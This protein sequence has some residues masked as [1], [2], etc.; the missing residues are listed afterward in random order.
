MRPFHYWAIA[1]AAFGTACSPTS[2]T[3]KTVVTAAKDPRVGFN[4][5]PTPAEPH[6][7][8]KPFEYMEA[9]DKL[10]NYVPSD[11]WGVQGDAITTMQKPLS[12]EESQKHYVLP[13]GFEAKLF[14][15]E[16]DIYKPI[17]LAW[18]ARGR[19]WISE[20]RD[21]PNEIQPEGQGRDQ[22]KICED[23]DGDGKADK[24]TVFADKLSIA[25]TFAFANGGIV[26]MQA[27]EALF[28]KD[29]DGDDKAD[30]RKVLFTGWSMNDTHATVSNLRMGPDG[31]LWG[32]VGY[33]GFRGTVGGQEHRFGQGFFRCKPDGSA[34]EFVR[35]SNNNTWGL[36]FD[37]NGVVFGSTANGNAYMYMPIANH[38]YEAVNGWSVSRVDSIATS[39]NF[40]PITKQVRQVDWH[41]KYTAGAGAALYTARSFPMEYWN[42]VGF[43]CEPTGH[44]IGQF[45][46]EAKGA[47]FVAHNLKTF[48]GSD[49]EW[50]SPI[51]AEVGPDGALWVTD[52]YNYII[53]H[54]P[55]PQGFKN[56][57]GNAY[58]TPLRDKTHGRIY[59]VVHKDSKPT[60]QPPRL[61]T[62]APDQLVAALKNE[63]LLWRT[64][65]QRLLV[66]RG[67]QDV[68]PALIKLVENQGTDSIGLNTAA[69][70]ALWTLGGL[71]ALNDA[72]S[73]A[74][75]AVVAALKHPAAGVRRNAAVVLP[76]NEAGR[77]ALLAAHA[78]DDADAQVKLA[79]LLAL[80]EM[81][82]S[83]AAGAAVFAALNTEANA[84]DKWLTDGAT[85][86]GANNAGGFLKATLMASVKTESLPGEAPDAVKRVAGHFGSTATYESIKPILDAAKTASPAA[87]APVLEGLAANWPKD[88]LPSLTPAQEKELVALMEA[89]PEDSKISLLTLVDTWK[90]KD[91]FAPQIAALSKELSAKVADTSL[92]DAV[93]AKSAARLIG[94]DD[95]E[96]S[97]K[98][99]VGQINL[100]TSPELV[101]G[102]VR[103]F[104][105]SRID[106][107]ATILI[108]AW[109]SL[110]PGSRRAAILTLTRRS[111]WT[112][113]LL[114]SVQSGKLIRSDLPTE[115]WAQLRRN[116]NRAIADLAREL[117]QSRVSTDMEATLAKI[118][119][120]TEK[121]G[122][123]ANGKAVFAK[124]CAVCHVMED[125]GAHIG[126]DLTGIGARAKNDF[127]V[128][129]ID[130]NRSVEANFRLWTATT[131]D[132]EMVSG[133]LESESQTG[134]EI[135]DLAGQK[136]LIQR[137]DIKA[138]EVSPMS[139]MPGGF[140]NLPPKDLTD[141]FEYMASSKVKH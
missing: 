101:T 128:D 79:S 78:L 32:V 36:A 99:I 109:D 39:Q 106:P 126:P 16:P 56:G 129:I 98:T 2:T 88:K 53:Q 110:T 1:L 30:E 86:A 132:D 15:H 14:A 82:A 24:F 35:S 34:M 23:T 50:T 124:N 59:R 21:Y 27:G 45:G 4:L 133:R 116:R 83:E 3:T 140:E 6:T 52:W 31:W 74:F 77:D 89:L 130:P 51:T 66:E 25:T 69:N 73:V 134:I 10:P 108:G 43:V 131:K 47:D 28:L 8:L 22:I 87:A 107:A 80:A 112:T 9:P 93:R 117:D 125:A 44:L 54:N 49:D 18:D 96:A 122:D 62:A 135:L 111:E 11:K 121:T 55:V 92:S 72:N 65:A 118:R 40:Y 114:K 70:H 71:G 13:A 81:P 94:F 139:I 26:V 104:G 37:E 127:F 7:G 42:R 61:D 57:K 97:L 102:L 103:A 68:V 123:V 75:K 63:N 84:T 5:P 137:K 58:E 119:P 138:L 100:Q 105:N 90:R 19:L 46:L 113:E 60:A 120:L 91:L 38:Y 115:V 64:H 85:A 141:L 20:T 29:T 48:L 67:Q 17:Y 41:G 136:H 12:P 33:S 95:S 76:H